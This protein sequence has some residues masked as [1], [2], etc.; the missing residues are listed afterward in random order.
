VLLK[1]SIKEL[2]LLKFSI[3]RD[4]T[5]ILVENDNYFQRLKVV[6]SEN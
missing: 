3:V 5:L 2:V 4:S 6:S 1:S